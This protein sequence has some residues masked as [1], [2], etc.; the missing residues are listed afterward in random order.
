MTNRLMDTKTKHFM[1]LYIGNWQVAGE[2]L[3]ALSV[4]ANHGPGRAPLVF[5]TSTQSSSQL[6]SNTTDLGANYTSVYTTAQAFS[7]YMNL[8]GDDGYIL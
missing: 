2:Q 5:S 1:H 3:S 8:K 4:I 7:F 6:Y